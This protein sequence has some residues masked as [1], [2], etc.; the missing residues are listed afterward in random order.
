MNG[1]KQN[2]SFFSA[3][4]LSLLIILLFTNTSPAQFAA[5]FTGST[6]S[7]EAPLAVM[8]TDLSHG[9]IWGWSWSFQGGSP[10]TA[11]GKGPHSVVYHNPGEYDVTLIIMGWPVAIRSTMGSHKE[12]SDI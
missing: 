4:L 8:F 1:I 11:S 3:G 12:L 7:G 6:T 5:Y 10:S 2:N 9:N